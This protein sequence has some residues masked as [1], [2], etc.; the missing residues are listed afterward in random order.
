MRKTILCSYFNQ[1]ING[2]VLAYAMP[3]SVNKEGWFNKYDDI[4]VPMQRK[5]IE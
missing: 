4:K 1:V 3:L 5:K 2:F